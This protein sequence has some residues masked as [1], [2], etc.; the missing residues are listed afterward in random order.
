MSKRGYVLIVLD[1]DNNQIF[2][3]SF[4]YENGKIKFLP[5]SNKIAKIIKEHATRESEFDPK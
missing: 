1:E 2:D 3:H 4:D 5:S